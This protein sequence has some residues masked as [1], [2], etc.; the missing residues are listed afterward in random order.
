MK[1]TRLQRGSTGESV[2]DWQRFLVSQG[3]DIGTVDGKFGTNTDNGTRRFQ[4]E[5]GLG[6]DGRVGPK[7]LAKA[8][9]HG[10]ALVD[11]DEPEIDDDEDDPT[12]HGGPVADE[13]DDDPASVKPARDFVAVIEDRREFGEARFP[14]KKR[15]LRR[16]RDPSLVKGLVLHQMAFSIGNDLRRYD[17]VTAH[18]VIMRDGQ[19]AWLHGHDIWL[20][21][22]NRPFNDTTIAVEFAGNLPSIRGRWW[23]PDKHGAHQLTPWQVGAGRFLIQHLVDTKVITHVFAHIQ[24]GGPNRSNCPGPD[25]WSSV[26]QWAVEKLGLDDGGPGFVARPSGLPIPDAWRTWGR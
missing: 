13:D 18:Y 11:E 23:K 4:S 14:A 6:V 20:P 19:I 7:T 9:E 24:A 17:N 1:L 8:L 10:F 5:H 2:T 15:H 21:A 22:S 26:G 12:G 16:H 25:I 3:I